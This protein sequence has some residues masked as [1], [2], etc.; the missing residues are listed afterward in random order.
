MSETALDRTN[1]ALDLIPFIASNP[2]WSIIE[3]AERFEST[4]AQIM[5]DLEMLFMCGLPGYSHS[6]LIDLDINEDYI[7]VRNPQNLD[8]PRRFSPEEV[9]ALT[10]GL[11]NL[12]PNITHEDLVARANVLL[13]HLASLLQSSEDQ[14]IALNAAEEVDTEKNAFFDQAVVSNE[15]VEID[16]FS[17]NSDSISTRTIL[18]MRTYLERGHMY[19][20]AFCFRADE[21]RH[22]RFDRIWRYVKV[23]GENHNV[24][25]ADRTSES[26]EI[27]IQTRLS[28]RNRY[29][30]EENH[31]II[32]ISKES[33]DDLL[34]DFT[35]SDPKWLINELLALPGKVEIIEPLA[36][37]NE[38]RA[39]LEAILALYR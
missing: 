17:A 26:P 11:A 6:E 34:V 20:V 4:P 18:P 7:A 33:L 25:E 12:L 10:L 29:F 15:S 14:H 28:K 21:I 2:G 16:Y 27:L 31:Q 19:L 8:K 30:V 3:L 9:I 13:L 37:R 35:I 5:K 24:V 32:S 38:Y 39:R 1:R 23:P 36:I 22:F